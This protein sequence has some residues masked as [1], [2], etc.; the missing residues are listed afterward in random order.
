[1][2][3]DMVGISIL[4]MH[5]FKR[6]VGGWNYSETIDVRL[7]KQPSVS[8]DVPS[9]TKVESPVGPLDNDMMGMWEFLWRLKLLVHEEIVFWVPSFVIFWESQQ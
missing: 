6:A 3:I 7:H 9:L 1:M 5:R 8:F 4:P 2:W